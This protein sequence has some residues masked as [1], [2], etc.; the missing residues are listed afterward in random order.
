[1]IR[2][3]LK[4]GVGI[5]HVNSVNYSITVDYITLWD[6]S[7]HKTATY[8]A[9]NVAGVAKLPEEYDDCK[10]Q[11]IREDI[12]KTIHGV[13]DCFIDDCDKFMHDNRDQLFK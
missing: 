2:V 13:D 11:L 12:E 7:G 6:D 10:D 5:T 1:M 9:N 4:N 8:I 3:F